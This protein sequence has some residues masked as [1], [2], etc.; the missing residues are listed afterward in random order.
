MKLLKIS[1]GELIFSKPERVIF[2]SQLFQLSPT[3]L[4]MFL[5]TCKYFEKL[6]LNLSNWQ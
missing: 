3:T 6:N 4:G 5:E 2:E 1:I